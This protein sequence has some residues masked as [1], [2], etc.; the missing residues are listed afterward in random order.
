MN[1]KRLFCPYREERLHMRRRGGRKRAIGKR[2][3]MVPPLIPSQ[4]WSLDLVSDQLTGG[5][6]FRILTVVDD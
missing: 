3:P 6:R 4:H 1:H 2:A 5:R